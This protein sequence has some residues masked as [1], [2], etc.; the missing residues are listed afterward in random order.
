MKKTCYYQGCGETGTTKEHI[1]PRSFFP[2]DQRNQ[3]LTVNSCPRHNNAKS[4]DDTYVLAQ[5]CMNASPANRAR[6]I[7]V[8]RVLPQLQFNGEALRKM[9]VKDSV[10]LEKGAVQ[11]KVDASRLDAFFS[12]LSF[13]IVRKACNSPLP[14]HY[15]VGH[16]YH[17]LVHD[18]LTEEG[19]N[20]QEAIGSFYSGTAMSGFDV[21]TVK[22]LN[23]SVYS[24][25]LFGMPGFKSSITVVHEFFGTFK[26]TSMLSLISFAS[27]G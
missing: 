24:V 16:I 26:V 7:F 3:L 8:D 13:G 6:E 2:G 4:S 21:G 19:R 20:L 23:S 17:N 22:T 9:L 27:D 12:A 25:K 1:P 10:P 18:G 11:Y 14:S 5:I 15:K